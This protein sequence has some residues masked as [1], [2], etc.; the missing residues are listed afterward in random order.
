MPAVRASAETLE[1]ARN[2]P[3][4]Y[5][6]EKPAEDEPHGPGRRSIL[7]WALAA[8]TLMVGVPMAASLVG[9][10]E[11]DAAVP[12]PPELSDIYDLG[13]LQDDAALPTSHLITVV[14]NQDGTASFALPRAEVGQG[15]TTSTTMLIAEELDLPMDKIAVTLADARP[16][17]LFNQLTG[18]SN[19][20]RSTYQA[21]RDA[22]ALARAKLVETAA[23]QWGVAADKL[24]TRDG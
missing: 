24:S 17:L 16:E 22:A 18:G 15:I 21:I 9:A 19:T 4:P 7:G 10:R 20:T 11:A 13:D 5:P 23:S 6:R 2:R 14:V 12:S 1:P 3:L 8:P